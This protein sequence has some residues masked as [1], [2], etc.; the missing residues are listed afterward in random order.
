MRGALGAGG[1]G[2]LS[3]PGWDCGFRRG[4]PWARQDGNPHG[5]PGKQSRAL[6]VGW[7][8]LLALLRTEWGTVT[9]SWFIA[10]FSPAVNTLLAV[11]QLGGSPSPALAGPQTGPDDPTGGFFA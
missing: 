6:G 7:R 8:V 5:S 9:S 1:G 4:C 3:R 11:S 2:G 10:A